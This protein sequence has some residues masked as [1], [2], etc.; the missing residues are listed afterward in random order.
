MSIKTAPA[1][2]WER[3]AADDNPHAWT[4]GAGTN[5]TD[6]WRATWGPRGR[7]ARRGRA[8]LAEERVE[9]RSAARPTVAGTDA[10]IVLCVIP[11]RIDDAT[12]LD[13]IAAMLQVGGPD[14]PWPSGADF[15]ED[16]AAII[17]QT[18]RATC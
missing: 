16:A 11:R 15:I 9:D 1:A 2:G 17:R 13:R 8:L 10:R 7:I 18:G 3:A 4:Y 6:D 5:M 12:A 14:V